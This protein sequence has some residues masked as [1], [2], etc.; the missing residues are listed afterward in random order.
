M[1]WMNK[2]GRVVAI[3]NA[4]GAFAN[5]DGF[6]LTRK[7]AEEEDTKTSYGEKEREQIRS[8]IYGS[9]YRPKSITRIHWLQDIPPTILA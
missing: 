6:S 1:Q 5:H 2:G 3:G 7:S 9:I 8:S 4:V